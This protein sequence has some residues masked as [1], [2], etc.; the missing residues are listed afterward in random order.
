M[1]EREETEEGSPEVGKRWSQRPGDSYLTRDEMIVLA[2]MGKTCSDCI[3]FKSGTYADEYVCMV[4]NRL[5]RKP[6][7]VCKKFR[8]WHPRKGKPGI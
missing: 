5:V 7:K 1:M 8:L 2:L 3:F 6:L 4:Q